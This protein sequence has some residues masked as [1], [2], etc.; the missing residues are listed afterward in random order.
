MVCVI[1]QRN[2]IQ[3]ASKWGTTMPFHC[4][5]LEMDL[6][7]SILVQ[8]CIQWHIPDK[9]GQEVTKT[10]RR[11]KELGQGGRTICPMVTDCKSTA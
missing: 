4:K 10:E 8:L 5:I 11:K 7:N 2:I 9:E 6:Q 3:R 1:L